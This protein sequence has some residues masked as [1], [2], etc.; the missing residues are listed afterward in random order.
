MIYTDQITLSN[1]FVVGI[2]YKKTDAALRGQFAINQEQYAKLL[3]FAPEHGLKELMVISTCNRTEIYGVAENSKKI[4]DLLCTQTKGSSIVFQ[5]IAYSKNG[6]DAIEHLFSVAAGLDS[7]ILG[8]YEIVGQIK[9]AFKFSKQHQSIG[10]FM[11]RLVNAVL[12]ASKSIRTNTALSSGTVSVA[13][14]AIE[15]LKKNVADVQDKNILIV[16]TGKIGKNISKN[17]V[18]YIGA[19]NITLINRTASS[20]MELAN[21]IGI[22]YASLD[23]LLIHIKQADIIVVATSAQE[24]IILKTDLLNAGN[25]M[26]IDLSIP[27]NVE[28]S[29]KQLSNICLV[30]VD[31]LSVIKDINLKKR[32]TEVPKA[33]LIIEEH[34]AEFLE[35]LALRK[36]VPVL[37]AVKNKLNAMQA[38]EL[39]ISYVSRQHI[40]AITKKDTDDKIQKV[41]NGMAIKMRIQNQRGC[42]YIQAINDF[43][44]IGTN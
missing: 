39:F 17:L 1:F 9:Q 22:Q 7:Q 5:Q 2:N 36:N 43:I 25:K 4:V 14:A 24:P 18:D 13:F 37:K 15:Y 26:I 12:Q 29:A 40:T 19:K 10:T 21:E 28:K 30:N 41:I 8:D 35:W 16:G 31:E 11:E 34:T 32:E 42:N 6:L 23:N 27:F 20:A 44:A 3:A 33:R 38:C